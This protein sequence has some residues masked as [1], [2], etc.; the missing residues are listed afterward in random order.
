MRGD[1][2]RAAA[3]QAGKSIKIVLH[4]KNVLPYAT[5]TT[6]DR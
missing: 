4:T 6:T 3:A 5:V 2:R 1:I